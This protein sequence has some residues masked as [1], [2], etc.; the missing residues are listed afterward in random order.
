MRSGAEAPYNRDMIRTVCKL[1]IILSALS[2]GLGACGKSESQGLDEGLDSEDSYQIRGVISYLSNALIPSAY[3]EGSSSTKACSK[4][5]SG[6]GETGCAYLQAI[7]DESNAASLCSVKLESLSQ[8]SYFYD[9]KIRNRRSLPE[10]SHPLVLKAYLPL[11]GYRESVFFVSPE[12]KIKELNVNA[13]SYLMAQLLRED[14]R[15]NGAAP[16]EADLAE[17]AL[18][19]V[20]ELLGTLGMKLHENSQG[21]P[22]GGNMDLRTVLSDNVRRDAL[23]SFIV[24]YGAKLREIASNDLELSKTELISELGATNGEINSVVS[25]FSTVIPAVVPIGNP[26]SVIN[27]NTVVLTPPNLPTLSVVPQLNAISGSVP[28]PGG[29]LAGSG[30]IVSVQNPYI[31][32]GP[33]AP[34]PGG[35]NQG[36]S[37]SPVWDSPSPSWTPPSSSP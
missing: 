32:G 9:F 16:I 4:E 26:N 12:D 1:S 14:R 24:K 13:E 36:G 29:S 18:D 28:Y 22:E 37:I 35:A 25:I 23:N 15:Q 5:C 34:L 21:F 10:F 33:I 19:R 7:D 6:E 30:A 31:S 8:G 3:A 11:G 17:G 20:V 2:M 27:S